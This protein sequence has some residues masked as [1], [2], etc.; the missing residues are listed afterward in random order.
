V[1]GRVPQSEY[2]QRWQRVQ[3]AA[4]AAGVEGVVVWSRGG[5][6]TDSYADVLYLTN[7]YS[8]FP[9]IGDVPRYWSGRSHSAVVLPPAGPPVLVTEQ[10]DWRRDLVVAGDVRFGLDL[11]AAVAGVVG[12]LGLAGARLGLV[13]GNAM[14]VS[15]YRFLL[16]RLPHVEW[17]A[18]DDLVEGVRVLKS[19]LELDLLREAATVGN[20]VMRRM[21]ETALEPGATEAEAVAAGWSYAISQAVAPYDAAVASGPNS[22]YYA[23]GRLP[24]WT[25]RRLEAGDFFHVDSYGSVGGYLYD[26][27]RACVVGGRPTPAQAE[28]LEAVIDC[29]RAGVDAIRP[30]VIAADVHRAVRR[31]LVEREM[32]PAD[33]G[34][35]GG[36]GAP[37]SA[38][39]MSF[40]AHG[41]SLGMSWENPWI[42]P[43]EQFAI[44][45]GMCIAVEAMAGRPGVGSA[46]CE[47]NVIVTDDGLELLTTTETHWW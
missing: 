11:P 46:K 17:V 34:E 3:E 47:Q 38:L 26:F 14:L 15:P 13:G 41:H 4:R 31:V 43:D 2:E 20:E 6:M 9:L 19:P 23:Y 36:D 42:L 5:A 45:A 32:V 10:P 30:G 33:D 16:E 39:T 21:I 25:T 35:G 37:V 18:V 24:S 29:V 44:Q 8:Q 7:Q 40:P 27:S 22:D 28:V 1:S 12:E